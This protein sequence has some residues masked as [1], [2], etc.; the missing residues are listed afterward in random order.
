M[1]I[2]LKSP[3]GN[4]IFSGDLKLTH[5]NGKPVKFEEDT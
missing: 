4:L 2:I 1:G 5:E 3:H